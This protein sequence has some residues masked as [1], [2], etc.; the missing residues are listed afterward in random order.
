[1]SWELPVAALAQGLP[2]HIGGHL[3]KIGTFLCNSAVLKQLLVLPLEM[4]HANRRNTKPNR[5]HLE[6]LL[7]GG[8]FK[9]DG[10]DGANHLFA[11]H[12]QAR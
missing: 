12:P 4:K 9:P 5:C 10:S 8:D 3:A 11:V 7:V 1:M 6:C 2:S